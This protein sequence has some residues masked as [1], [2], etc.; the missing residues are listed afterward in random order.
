MSGLAPTPVRTGPRPRCGVCQTA[1]EP[2]E[3]VQA[4]PD[5]AAPHHRECWEENGGCAIYGCP[6]APTTLKAEPELV[7]SH[8]G[9]EEKE[10]AQCHQRIK[11]AALRCR[12][13]GALLGPPGAP[14]GPAVSRASRVPLVIF[15]AGIVPV[16]APFAIAGGGLWLLRKGRWRALTGTQKVLVA[17]GLAIAAVA[18]LLGGAVLLLGRTGD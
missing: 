16:T 12:F 3:E 15:L 14:G 8:W 4:C 6:R 17:L 13:C 9:Q 2:G 7:Q 11:V 5:C 18:V 10:C 1:C